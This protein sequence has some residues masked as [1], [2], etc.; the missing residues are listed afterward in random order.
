MGSEMPKKRHHEEQRQ[1]ADDR[2]PQPDSQKIVEGV[3]A[4]RHHKE[5]HPVGYRRQE[6]GRACDRDGDTYRRL[7]AS[8]GE[9]A[10][11]YHFINVFLQ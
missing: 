7:N 3:S 10:E 9:K 6:G 4:R 1:E 5:I 11:S 2:H 8:L